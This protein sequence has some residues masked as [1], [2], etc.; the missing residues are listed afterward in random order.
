MTSALLLV[1]LITLYAGTGA[2]LRR[3]PVV[4]PY[5]KP[6]VAA[7]IVFAVALTFVVYPSDP[8]TWDGERFVLYLAEPRFEVLAILGNL[9]TGGFMFGAFV[10]GI[11][12]S[13]RSR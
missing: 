2:V 13:N 4:S 7:A 6:L 8:R 12:W 3:M 5:K 10:L 1:S 11:Y 9:L